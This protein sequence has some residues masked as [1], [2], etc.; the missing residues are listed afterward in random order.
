M[1]WYRDK[2]EC[3]SV[4]AR[5]ALWKDAC[6]EYLQVFCEKH[7]YQ[8]EPDMWVGS[9]PGTIAM[10][11]DMFVSMENIRYDID[12]DIPEEYFEK[13]YWKSLELDEIGV[14]HWMNYESYCKGAPDI[15]T[16]ERMEEIRK[17]RSRVEES[18]RKFEELIKE[19]QEENKF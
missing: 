12:N 13:W 11:G 5:K 6:N 16:E 8:Y 7:E 10:I 19:Y 2:K 3:V 15:W 1:E 18:K 17:A 14:E 4:Q 9:N